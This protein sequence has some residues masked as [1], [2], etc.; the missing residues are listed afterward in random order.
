VYHK[1]CYRGSKS[2]R[3]IYLSKKERVKSAHGM[4]KYVGQIKSRINALNNQ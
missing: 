1:A 3:K 2:I 4:G